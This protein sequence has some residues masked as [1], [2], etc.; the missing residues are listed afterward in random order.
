[1]DVVVGGRRAQHQP[2]RRGSVLFGALVMLH[3]DPAENRVEMVGD[4]AGRVDVSRAG[5]AQLVDNNPVPLRDG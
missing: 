1:M 3:L 2:R 4:I 5:A